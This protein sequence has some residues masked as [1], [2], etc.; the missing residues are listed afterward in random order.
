MIN[1]KNR[2]EQ[3]VGQS[4]RLFREQG[5]VA[6]S[7]RDIGG[8]A[9]MTSAALYYHFPN[10]DKLLLGV[11]SKALEVVR[12]AVVEAT[13]QE[14][15]AWSKLTAAVHAHLAISTQ[16]QDFAIVLLQEMRHLSDESRAEVIQQR[17]A[18][19]KVWDELLVA[20]Q[21]EGSIRKEVNLRALRLM[22]FGALNLVVTWYRESGELSTDDIATAFLDFLGNG[23]RTSE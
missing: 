11:M 2:V 5:F 15:S 22:V 3:I 9:G 17:D 12:K 6:S 4:A 1:A 23:V 16:H 14:G 18:Y 8:A 7:I 20:A 19:Q 13:E 21:D 10:K